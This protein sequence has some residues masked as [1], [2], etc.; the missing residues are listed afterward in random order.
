MGKCGRVGCKRLDSFHSLPS[1]NDEYA[2]EEFDILIA[3]YMQKV[4]KPD[5]ATAW[6]E[7]GDENEREETY[8]LASYKTLD[9]AIK[10]L[11]SFM[12]LFVCDRSDRV[13]EGKTA[14]QVQMCGIFRG[15]A[16]VLVRA[17]MALGAEGITMKISVRSNSAEVAEY[18]ASAID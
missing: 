3:D 2:L 18:I 17:K 13:P 9:E 5:F 15:A 12:D 6:T 1:Y 14:H 7:L 16:E 10:N 11:V 4:V 8:A